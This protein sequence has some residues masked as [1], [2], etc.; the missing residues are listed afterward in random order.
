MSDTIAAIATARAAGA[1][2]ILRLS[3]PGAFAAAGAVFRPANGRPMGAQPPRTLVYGDVL[4]GDGRL[5]DHGLCVFFPAPRSYTGEDCAELHCHGSPLVLEEGLRALFAAGARQAEAGEFTRRAFL[6]GRMD[7][8]QA[9]A[10]ADLI[11]A[12]TATAAR[13]AAAQLSGSLSRTVNGVYDA[14]LSLVSRFY[15]VVDYPDED[16]EPHTRQEMLDVL[17]QNEAALSALAATFSRGRVLKSGV[18][19]ALLGKP[20]V[21]KSSL[22]N[23]LLGFDRAIVA[24]RPGTTR[25]TVEEKLLLGGVLLRLTDTAGIR[26]TDDAVEQQGVARSRA[27]AA[28]AELALLV[29]DGSAP[30]DAEDQEAAALA[31]SAPHCLLLLNKSDLPCRA[32]VSALERRFGA[33]YPVSA[34]TGAGLDALAQ[35]VSAL[36]PSGAAAP[37]ELLTNA[38]QYGAVCR[39]RDA[40]AAARDA[41]SQGVTPDAVLADAE[42]ALSALGELNG[43]TVR[44]DVV[45]EIFS[46]F[47]VGK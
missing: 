30:P 33:V 16:I 43:R 24:S 32:D 28:G 9:E 21:G 18:P 6:N 10:V 23:A 27:A 22:L 8:L 37:G 34:V 11:D 36:Y 40:L 4:D 3:G 31:L 7:L 35:A 45:S 20:N 38:R 41:L 39:A 19:A 46:R 42:S 47:C 15:A 29:L 17:E 2:G 5:L 25:D 12:E 1:V 44:E 26:S 13:H 14:L